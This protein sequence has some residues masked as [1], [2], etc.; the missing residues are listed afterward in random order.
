MLYSNSAFGP[1]YKSVRRL[2]TQIEPNY[3]FG[4]RDYKTD[5]MLFA[6]TQV[7]ITSNV[8]TLTVQLEAGG[9]PSPVN[10]LPVVG[11]KMGVRGTQTNSGAFNVDPAT[12]TAT[13]ISAATGTGTL[14]YALT[15]ANVAAV[16]DSGVVVVQSVEVAD[17]VSSGSASAPY[18]LVFTP[19]ESDNSRCVGAEVKWTG[20]LPSAAV[21]V[22]QGANVDDESRYMTIGNQQGLAPGGVVATS[23]ALASISGSAVTQSGAIYIY[24]AFKF[25]RMKVLSMSGGDGT[26]GVIGTIFA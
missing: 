12:L 11:A 16:V 10:G 2:S 1:P 19:D 21:V 4:G 25:L 5:N 17:L 7:A 8:A 15:H 22:L 23:D 3:V 9:G 6:I 14:S 18:A 24:V 20:T 13:T 26:T